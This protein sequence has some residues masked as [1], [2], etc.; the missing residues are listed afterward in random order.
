MFNVPV[1]KIGTRDLNSHSRIEL[2]TAMESP[3]GASKNSDHRVPFYQ[4]RYQIF[5]FVDCASPYNLTNKSN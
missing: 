4:R 1:F 2:G 5:W 3:G